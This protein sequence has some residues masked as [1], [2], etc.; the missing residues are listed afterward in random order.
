MAVFLALAF[1]ASVTDARERR[2]PN[3]ALAA[4]AVCAL[5]FQATRF[6]GAPFAPCDPW[7]VALCGTLPAPGPLVAGALAATAVAAAVELGARRLGHGMLGMGDVK[8][9]GCWALLL[10][11]G[12]AALA[13]AAGLLLG[14]V[15]A[16]LRRQPTFAV[17][18]WACL[19]GAAVAFLCAFCPVIVSF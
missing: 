14:A 7:L 3:V 13:M 2:L 10:G 11:W 17:G 8:L 6:A 12:P 18:P 4:M 9:F 16:F 5:A 19:A 15:V 1:W